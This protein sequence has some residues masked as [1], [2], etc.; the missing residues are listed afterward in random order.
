M[1][2]SFGPTRPK[3]SQMEPEPG[4]PLKAVMTSLR[5]LL[6]YFARCKGVLTLG[7]FCVLGSAVF[8]LVKPMV[9]GNAVDALTKAI[10]R[11]AMIRYALLYVGAAAIEGAFLY[12]QR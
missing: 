9:V 6:L 10:S 3:W 8:S 7:A 11:G 5:R 4:P 12:L 1:W 2:I